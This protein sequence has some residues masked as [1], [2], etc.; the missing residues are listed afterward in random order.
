MGR[1][2]GSRE[3]SF[4]KAHTKF[5]GGTGEQIV[6]VQ[7]GWVNSGAKSKVVNVGGPEGRVVRLLVIRAV[8]GSP[9]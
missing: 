8:M 6:I 3:V 9:T 2:H 7:G 4:G 5:K 1:G